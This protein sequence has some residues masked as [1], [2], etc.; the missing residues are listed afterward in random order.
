VQEL[1]DHN[2]LK[3]L[4][5][6]AFRA[7][8]EAEL[9]LVNNP[10]SLGNPDLKSE[11]VKTWELIWVGQWPRASI[12]L[13][14]FEN[15]YENSISHVFVGI[16]SLRQLQNVP[17][18]PTKGFELDLSH[19]LSEHWLIRASYTHLGEK[20]YLSYREADQLASLM[21]NYQR[22][23]WNANLI[24]TY[25]GDREMAFGGDESNLLKLN[26]FWLAF[27]K[28]SYSFSDD[29]QAFVQAKNLLDEDYLT[30]VDHAMIE[31]IQNRGR[32]ILAGVIWAF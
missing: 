10:N 7:P 4:Y 23:S 8:V 21:V 28:L 24:A 1:N 19:Q 17:Q 18:E 14:Y 5:G 13:G 16:G 25:D 3:L 27:A 29:W 6:E 31:G 12:S 22:G 15:Q 32:E 20:P 2:S 30:P 9:N 11:T 26:G